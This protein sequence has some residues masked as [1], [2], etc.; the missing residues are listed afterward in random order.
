MERIEQQAREL[1][2]LLGIGSDEN[3]DL[4]QDLNFAKAALT[5]ARNAGEEAALQG[6]YIAQKLA[7]AREAGR[8]EMRGMCINHMHSP[9]C[10]PD[11]RK[12]V[13]GGKGE[14][15][16]EAS[17]MV[18]EIVAKAKAEGVEELRVK[19]HD[20]AYGKYFRRGNEDLLRLS[21]IAELIQPPSPPVPEVPEW[22]EKWYRTTDA[23]LPI[24]Q[25]YAAHLKHA[26]PATRFGKHILS[27]D[28][29]HQHEAPKCCSF[30]CAC[31]APSTTAPKVDAGKLAEA[32]MAM[33]SSRPRKPW[34][35]PNF[36]RQARSRTIVG[37]NPKAAFDEGCNAGVAAERERADKELEDVMLER[38][39]WEIALSEA[40][41]ALG[42]DGEWVAHLPP[43]Y[44][45]ES[46]DLSQ[47]V[48][49]LARQLTNHITS[50]RQLADRVVEAAKEML[51]RRGHCLNGDEEGLG[52]AVISICC[53]C[54]LRAALTD[55]EKER[56]K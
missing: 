46:G 42:G 15:L 10:C 1:L 20:R 53:V 51:K 52:C 50:E 37:E 31:R 9:T 25:A 29:Q 6:P 28:E 47:D 30:D 17:G 2:T 44:P 40:H 21:D 3:F 35:A 54:A 5:A 49:E 14:G 16:F 32:F 55:Y 39:R 4:E 27:C 12:L 23:A 13:E 34:P 7:E 22:F 36:A 18:P 19:L 43:Q 48:P 56:G 8:A 41:L 24:E 11:C 38:D 45:P 33:I 26:P